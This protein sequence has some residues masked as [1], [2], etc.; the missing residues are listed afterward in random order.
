MSDWFSDEELDRIAR[1]AAM[2]GH[3][4]DPTMLLPEPVEEDTADSED[5]T[6][7]VLDADDERC[8]G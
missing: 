4:R 3:S 8:E 2:P 1:F 5:A 6:D 7:T